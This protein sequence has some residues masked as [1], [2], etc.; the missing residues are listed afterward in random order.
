MFRAAVI[1]VCI[2]LT[3]CTFMTRTKTGDWTEPHEYSRHC[4]EAAARSLAEKRAIVA[5]ANCYPETSMDFRE[6]FAQAYV[7]VALGSDGTVPAVPPE[8][9]WK[10]CKRNPNG[11][12]DANEWFAGYAAGSQRAL[13]SC[14]NAYNQVPSSGVYE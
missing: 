8:R 2:G 11:Y 14:W 9:Y 13:A 7:D 6:G 1:C 10:T 12:C 3:G 5:I 4:D